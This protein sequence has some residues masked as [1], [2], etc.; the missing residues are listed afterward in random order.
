M[1]WSLAS[2]MK[3][4]SRFL[5]AQRPSKRVQRVESQRLKVSKTSGHRTLNRGR[6]RIVFVKLQHGWL[7][8][9][10]DDSKPPW[11]SRST[12]VATNP[13]LVGWSAKVVHGR[14]IEREP[15]ELASS[16]KGCRWCRP[17]SK[18]SPGRS[19]MT[20]WK[21]ADCSK[22]TARS[23]SNTSQSPRRDPGLERTKRLRFDRREPLE[24]PRPNGQNAFA[25]TVTNT[26]RCPDRM[27]K[28][29]S[30]RPSRTLRGAPIERT[31]RLRSDRREHIDIPRKN[32]QNAFA[33]T[34]ANTSR[35][36]DR[37]N[38]TRSTCPKNDTA[39]TR[40]LPQNGQTLTRTLPRNRARLLDSLP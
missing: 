3:K 34:V 17:N 4:T 15:P 10:R 21:L 12:A 19:Q 30:L 28:P 36:P 16:N 29:P 9:L 2:V 31:N 5:V 25:S 11:P 38:K 6:A 1:S 7:L 24:V 13:P 40:C 22:S 20:R 23:G 27:E 33:S 26:S 37:T 35:C 8:L 14:C 32:E 39:L 18:R